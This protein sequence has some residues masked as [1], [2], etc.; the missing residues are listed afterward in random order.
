MM[1]SIV[2]LKDHFIFEFVH[3]SIVMGQLKD[4]ILFSKCWCTF[5]ALVKHVGQRRHEDFVDDV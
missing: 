2:A 1:H 5:L 3:G 4:K